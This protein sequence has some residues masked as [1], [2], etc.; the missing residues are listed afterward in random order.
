MLLLQWAY[1]CHPSAFAPRA[2][3][4]KVSY[5][6]GYREAWHLARSLVWTADLHPKEALPPQ[7]PSHSRPFY[8]PGHFPDMLWL[9]VQTCS[10]HLSFKVHNTWRRVAFARHCSPFSQNHGFP[11]AFPQ[12][13]REALVACPMSD[14]VS[15]RIERELRQ[16]FK[17]V[18]IIRSCATLPIALCYMAPKRQHKG[19]FRGTV[20]N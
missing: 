9:E 18:L 6:L 13:L 3:S 2:Q 12:N 14:L 1:T 10:S 20:P 8:S 5:C 4:A 7:S 11:I 15:I 16:C 19:S 17:M